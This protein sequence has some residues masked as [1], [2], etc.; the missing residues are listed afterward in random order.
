VICC[1]RALTK[2]SGRRRGEAARIHCRPHCGWRRPS[3]LCDLCNL[4]IARDGAP[5]KAVAAGGAFGVRCDV[6][7]G[8]I[9]FVQVFIAFTVLV[10]SLSVHEAA[11]AWTADRLGDPTAR[12][13]GRVTINPTAHVDPIGTVLFPLIAMLTRLPLIGWAKPVPVNTRNLRN[14]RRDYV[15]VAAA[16]PISNLLLACLGALVWQ[17]MSAGEHRDSLQAVVASPLHSFVFLIVELNV[18]LAV[19]NMIPVPPLDGGNV[20][21]GLLPYRLAAEYDRLRPWGIVILYAL[22]LSG[23]LSV[24]VWPVARAIVLWML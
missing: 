24:V 6:L 20:L 4:W 9:D 12:M 15:F 10:G 23:A 18:L 17:V 14:P 19:F 22:M 11:H 5:R 3:H 2:T 13:L 21:G 16:G 7:Q 1:R 8:G